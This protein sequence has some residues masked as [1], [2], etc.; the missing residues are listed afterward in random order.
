MIEVIYTKNVWAFSWDQ[1]NC[2]HYRGVRNERFD[3][4]LFYS[5]LP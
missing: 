4:T 3:C 1:E 5:L 2:P